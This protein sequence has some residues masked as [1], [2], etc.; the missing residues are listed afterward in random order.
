MEF[1][2]AKNDDAKVDLGLKICNALTSCRLPD[3]EFYGAKVKVLPEMVYS[4]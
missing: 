2:K 4:N 1:E 3:D